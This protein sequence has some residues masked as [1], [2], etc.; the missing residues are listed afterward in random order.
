[1]NGTASYAYVLTNK[2]VCSIRICFVVQ[3]AMVVA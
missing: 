2:F 1:M 3:Y